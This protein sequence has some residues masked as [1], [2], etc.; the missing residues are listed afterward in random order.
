ML[1]AT[2]DV[3]LLTH[4]NFV[5]CCCLFCSPLA[6]KRVNGAGT[7]AAAA[8]NQSTAKADARVAKISPNEDVGRMLKAVPLLSK[9][10]DAERAKLGGAVKE[11]NFQ[12]GQKIITQVRQ[13]SGAGR[14]AVLGRNERL[15]LARFTR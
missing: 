15:A 11:K 1:E 2:S 7:A 8:A 12:Q 4:Q 10:S 13:I 5:C 3:F 14:I 9:L 6:P